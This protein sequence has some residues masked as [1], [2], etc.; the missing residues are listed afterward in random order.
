MY[1]CIKAMTI[2]PN[3]HVR[4]GDTIKDSLYDSLDWVEQDNFEP[5]ADTSAYEESPSEDDISLL[6]AAIDI[7]AIGISVASIFGDSTTTDDSSTFDGFDGGDFGGGG[8]GSD[9]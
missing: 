8:A 9:F 2:F 1:R 5:I 3:T 6:D 7:A 4:V